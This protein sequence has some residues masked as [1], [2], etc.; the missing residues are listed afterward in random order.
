[1]TLFLFATPAASWL[2]GLSTDLLFAAR[3]AAGF[4]PVSPDRPPAVVI[5][6]DEETYRRPPFEATP[7]VAWTPLLGEVV[8]AVLSSGALVIGQ[9][10]ILPT[11]L[12]TLVPGHDRPYLAALAAGAAGNRIVLGAVRHQGE[13]VGPHPAHQLL[14]RG[15]ANIRLL[16]LLTDPDGVIRRA[17]V[18]FG[19][20]GDSVSS[21]PAEL[22]ARAAKA[23]PSVGP[24][25]IGPGDRTSP[26]HPD[27]GLLLDFRGRPGAIP[28]H[29][30]ADILACIREDRT[31]YLRNAFEG[32]VV[33]IGS[34]LDIEDRKT[35]SARYLG[36]QDG[37]SFAPRCVHPVMASIY[38]DA[39]VRATI[40]GVLVHARAVTD[41]LAGGGL[42]ALPAWLQA[43]AILALGLLAAAV[44]L[45]ASPAQA[46]AAMIALVLLTACGALA[47]FVG[48]VTTPWLTAEAAL[49]AVAGV[50]YGFR[51]AVTDRNRRYLRR[52][53]A[54][55]LSPA[56]VEELARSGRAPELGG[57]TREVTIWFSDLAS[58]TKLSESMS[59]EELVAALNEYLDIVSDMIVSNRGMIDKYIGD[60]VVGVFGA[61]VDDPDHARHALD[62]ARTCQAR[63]ETFAAERLARSGRPWPHTRLGLNTGPA[64]VGNIGSAQRF[65]YTVMGDAVNLAARLESLNKRYGS[66]V[67]ISRATAEADNGP[68]LRLIDRVQVVGRNEA[69]DVYGLA[70]GLSQ[71]QIQGY[72]AARQAYEDGDFEAAAKGFAA[73]AE[74]DPVSGRMQAFAEDLA[75]SPPPEWTGVSV[76]DKK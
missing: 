58:F 19:T 22:A 67:L 71:A 52:T 68:D 53:F 49:L 30:L 75:A 41:L 76:L 54:R 42:R 56:V 34:M 31:G 74:A 24:D 73:L 62:A 3:H 46:V 8:S 14:I 27:G 23:A 5:A 44:V 4:E 48:G 21:F 20:E 2:N 59:P 43:A 57:E 72:E 26:L 36:R 47:A 32:R 39:V 9:D 33:L 13:Q 1:M 63:L 64:L 66:T 51:F 60:A 70:T 15:A 12:E 55:Y 7:K 25:S 35:T 10:L 16:N 17:P 18:L 40:P 29:S 65:D 28:V 50:S 11:S 61:P 37:E 69:T 45:A 38:E 6:I